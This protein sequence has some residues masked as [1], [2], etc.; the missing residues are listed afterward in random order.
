[1]NNWFYMDRLEFHNLLD[2]QLGNNLANILISLEFDTSISFL[3]G[4]TSEEILTKIQQTISGSFCRRINCYE[5]CI[6]CSLNPAAYAKLFWFVQRLLIM[7]PLT[8]PFIKPT[9]ITNEDFNR[10]KD[11][12]I[13]LNQKETSKNNQNL[14]KSSFSSFKKTAPMIIILILIIIFAL[15]LSYNI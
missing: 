10:I 6:N 15:F 1:M 3:I 14:I 4:E 11:K 9:I 5:S 7:S 13:H 8:K 12:T 2:D